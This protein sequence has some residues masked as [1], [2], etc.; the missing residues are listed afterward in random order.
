M[1]TSGSDPKWIS[2][3]LASRRSTR[4]FLPTPIPQEILDQILTDSLTAP[5]WSNTRPFKVAIATGEV[6]DRISNEFLSRWGVLSQIMRKGIKNKLRLIYSRYGLPT[7]NRT[8]VKP[9][10]AELRPRAQRVGKELYELFGVKRGDRAARDAQWAKNYSFFGAPV[11][12][13]I[14]IHK[15]LHVYAASDAGLMM[16][17]LMLSAHAHG[18]GTCA[19]GAVNIWD[20]VVR[21]EF[22]ISKDYRLLCGLAIGYPSNSPVNS[23]KADRIDKSQMIVKPRKQR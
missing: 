17:N 16:E 11:E 19:Q 18:L 5:S 14:Y 6:K 10:V 9:Y 22:E 1:N 4:D 23:F 15:S 2:E 13:F 7:S 8:I 3:F 12:L 21:K 20:D